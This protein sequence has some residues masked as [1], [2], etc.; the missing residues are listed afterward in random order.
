MT[1]VASKLVDNQYAYRIPGQHLILD[2][3]I[4]TDTF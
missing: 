3:I 2:F 1:T 4:F